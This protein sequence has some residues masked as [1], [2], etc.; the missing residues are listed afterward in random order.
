MLPKDL[1][2]AS[3]EP[4]ILNPQQCEAELSPLNPDEL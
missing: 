3:A 4:L 1:F 2:A